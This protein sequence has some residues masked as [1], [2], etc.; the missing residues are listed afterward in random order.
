MS[1]AEEFYRRHYRGGV[2]VGST[3]IAA[4][5]REMMT[6]GKRY[7][8]VEEHFLH[9]P[10]SGGSLVEIGCGGGEAIISL[11]QR[12]SFERVVGIDIALS[13]FHQGID[14]FTANLDQQWPFADGEVDYLIAMMVLEHL[15]DP[16]HSFAEIKR[17]LKPS[18]YA[19]VNLP[20]VTAWTNRLRL[21][22]GGLPNTSSPYE[23]WFEKRGWD[24]NHLHYFSLRSI[25][26]LAA[27]SGLRLT[28]VR[29]VG[30]QY[31]LKSLWPSLLASEVTF[32]LTH[33]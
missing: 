28:E 17:I 10:P 3:P 24:G 18:G 25:T 21:L 27:F 20:L 4:F 6:S 30:S 12:Y 33:R 8:L 5:E 22:I 16:F 14:F 9:H 7:A 23:S 32:Q 26:D 13:G 11:S 31:R 29:G 19:F 15:Y 1:S 2:P